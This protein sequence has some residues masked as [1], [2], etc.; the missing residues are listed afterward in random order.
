[1]VGY[2]YPIPVSSGLPVNRSKLAETT[3]NRS[4]RMTRIE[5]PSMQ[6]TSLAVAR[7]EML[8]APLLVDVKCTHLRRTEQTAIGF[9]IAA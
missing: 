3:G 6:H 4:E 9:R 7:S 1:M 2:S 5:G 8:L